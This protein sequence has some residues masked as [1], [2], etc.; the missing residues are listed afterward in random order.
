M[1]KTAIMSTTD[2]HAD[3]ILKRAKCL[4][5]SSACVE[6]AEGP[7]HSPQKT[8][9]FVMPLR[10]LLDVKV[11]QGERL[12]ATLGKIRHRLLRLSGMGMAW[13]GDGKWDP[14][15]YELL[16][17]TVIGLDAES[18]LRRPLIA[19]LENPSMREFAADGVTAFPAASVFTTEEQ[20][21]SCLFG[22]AP[23]ARADSSD[24]WEEDAPMNRQG[25]RVRRV[26]HRL[27]PEAL[28]FWSDIDAEEK[29]R[30]DKPIKP[31]REPKPPVFFIDYSLAMVLVQN[32]K[33][34]PGDALAAIEEVTWP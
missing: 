21:W 34:T 16:T 9:L 27:H 23:K 18:E 15:C 12:T 25:E 24:S 31:L 17:E 19:A 13:S 33:K 32:A 28:A 30:W 11:E 7:E 22:L 10:A 6:T 14:A 4:S 5:Y 3:P 1:R 2:L 20:R 8:P 29:G 26:L